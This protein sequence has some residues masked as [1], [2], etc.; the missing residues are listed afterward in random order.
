MR[1]VC[2]FNPISGAGRA[3][4]RAEAVGEAI[5]SSGH[6]AVLLETRRESAEDW[7]DPARPGASALVGCGGDG[8]V[9][10]ASRSAS[11]AGVPIH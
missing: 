3:R 1:V 11:R 9:R 5:R 6:E 4:A 8:A 7:L 10:L 2:L